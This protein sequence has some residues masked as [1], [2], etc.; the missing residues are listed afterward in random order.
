MKLRRLSLLTSG[1]ALGVLIVCAP[2]CWA[3]EGRL[4]IRAKPSQAYVFVDG[5]PIGDASLSGFKRLIVTGLSPGAHK[6]SIYNYGY[7]PETRSVEVQSGRTT[8]LAVELQPLSGTVSGPWGRLQIEGAPRAAVLLNGKTPDFFVGH[9]DEFDHD[10]FWK[11]ELLLPPGTYQVTL[12][13]PLTNEE[14]YSGSVTLKRDQRVILYVN[15][16]GQQVTKDWR[17]GA[18]LGALSRFRA[19]LASAT[20]AVGPITSEFAASKGKIGCG[21]P[22]RLTWK[23]SGAVS[24]ELSGMGPVP[25]SG[26]QTVEPKDT[27]TYKFRAAGP[28]GVDESSATVTVDKTVAASLNVAPAEVRY[29]RVGDKEA[30]GGTAT[31]SWTTSN[32]SSVS[33]EGLGP[34][35]ASGSQALPVKPQRTE[36]GAVDETVTYTLNATNPCGGAETKTATLHIVGSIERMLEGNVTETTLETKLSLNSIYFPTA[37][38]T[39]REPTGGLVPSQQRTLTELAGNF[40]QY[41]GFRPEAHLILEAHADKRGGMKFNQALTERRAARVKS[42]LLEQ[43]VPEADIETKAFGDVKNLDEKQV[44]QLVGQ[45]ATLAPDDKKK[46]LRNL[47]TIVLANNR[48][49][50]VVLSTTGQQSARLYPY[51]APDSRELLA[52][53]RGK[54]PAKAKK[55]PAGALKKK[56]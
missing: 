17:R 29:H 41:L 10:I 49:V 9:A 55:S 39:P 19:G 47:R 52:E 31:V 48:R 28:G 38:P 25:T 34:V 46:I 16:N 22:V 33:I 5:L 30:E 4:L 56:K 54:R 12:L 24:T 11:Q 14:V 3:Q 21:E 20:V 40:K 27:T 13:R 44:R 42:S 50:D 43:G 53:A 32:A 36:P 15:R 2:F 23:T 51:N 1:L 26:E 35:G 37:M 18:K 6:I 7:Q 45:D 8:P